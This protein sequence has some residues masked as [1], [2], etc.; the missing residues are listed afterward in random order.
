[1][2]KNILILGATSSIARELANTFAAQG[3]HLFLASRDY[4]E[5]GRIT[6]DIQIRYNTH[7]DYAKFDA[8]DR[9]SHPEFWQHVL[10]KMGKVDGVV[11]ASGYLEPAQLNTDFIKLEK[12]IAINFT[13]AVSILQLCGNYFAQNKTGFII[14]LSSVAGDRARQSNNVYGTAKG[15]LSLYLQGLRN[16]LAP[17]HVQVLT[18]KLGFVDTA[19]TY[20]MPGLFLVASPALIAKKIVRA[21]DKK[22]NIIYL[23]FFWRYIMLIICNIPEKVFKR[24]KL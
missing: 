4:S 15:A 14:G 13:G 7:V 11:Y 5:L 20:G 10:E 3:H 18:V 23:P 12:I 17:Y 9:A 24:L 2:T 16:Q 6:S 21:L 1:M 19:M 8:E 22:R